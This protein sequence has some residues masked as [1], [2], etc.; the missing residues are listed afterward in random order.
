MWIYPGQIDFESQT[1]MMGEGDPFISHIEMFMYENWANISWL[2]SH[3][4]SLC[5]WRWPIAHYN[6]SVGLDSFSVCVASSC[7]CARDFRLLNI[8]P[9]SN[10]ASFHI[11]Q[12]IFAARRWMW[13]KFHRSWNTPVLSVNNTLS[14]R[15]AGIKVLVLTFRIVSPLFF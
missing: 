4:M 11:N 15:F 2:P 14:N 6:R 7:E 1:E 10:V 13:I 3:F 12:F 5:I 9:K 8:K